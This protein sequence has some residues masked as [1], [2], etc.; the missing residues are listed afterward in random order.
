MKE[1]GVRRDEARLRVQ[2]DANGGLVPVPFVGTLWHS[3]G[4]A[5]WRRRIGGTLVLM[6]GTA[7]VGGISTGVA[8]GI[9][10]GGQL[11]ATRVAIAAIYL[12]TV[13]PGLMY[14][15]RIV[16]RMPL[17]ARAGPSNPFGGCLVVLVTPFVTGVCLDILLAALRPQFLG[18]TR[19]RALSSP[20]R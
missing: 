13:L 18:E 2:A 7:F 4:G 11:N 20:R 19:A 1:K 9:L 16:R 5:Y 14:G 8:I 10:G 12:A 15:Q 3:R 17:D 6:V